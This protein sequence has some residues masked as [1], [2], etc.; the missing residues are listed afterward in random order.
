MDSR[1]R[2]SDPEY[3]NAR[4]HAE[5]RFYLS[6]IRWMEKLVEDAKRLHLDP[7]ADLHAHLDKV[8]TAAW[9]GQ[10]VPAEPLPSVSPDIIVDLVTLCADYI[11]A[12]L[13]AFSAL[14]HRSQVANSQA[15][16]ELEKR[17]TELLQETHRRKWT[18]NITEILKLF[19]GSSQIEEAWSFV[20]ER[21]REFVRDTL[22]PSLWFGVDQTRVNVSE[23]RKATDS[24]S[25]ATIEAFILKIAETGRKI[26]RTEIWL[27]AG[28]SDKTEFERF[29]RDDARTTR[30]ARKNFTRVLNLSPESF[31]ELLDRLKR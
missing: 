15:V 5:Q 1:S 19:P 8:A 24:S 4:A 10:P 23:V 2:S 22:E 20:R 3:E 21:T 12:D 9:A 26:S 30:T 27:A 29:Q 31:I 17:A 7:I 28:Y 14:M 16:I 13:I 25:R 11:S 6:S 18:P